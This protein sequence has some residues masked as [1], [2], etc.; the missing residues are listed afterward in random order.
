VRNCLRDFELVSNA[1]AA[2]IVEDFNNQQLNQEWN[3]FRTE[4]LHARNARIQEKAVA[5]QQ[6]Q[7][8]LGQ[9]Q[10]NAEAAN[11]QFETLSAKFSDLQTALE[12][13]MNRIT[14]EYHLSSAPST[15]ATT[16]CLG[17]RAHW[18]DCAQKYA[19]DSRPC[20][21][22]FLALEKCVQDTVKAS[23]MAK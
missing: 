5:L 16:K 15:T 3:K 20:D 2:E 4:V 22:Y 7:Q 6:K 17:E 21:A 13:D 12:Y 23:V 11:H 19:T 1:L 9:A 10:Q 14:E 18:V 8:D